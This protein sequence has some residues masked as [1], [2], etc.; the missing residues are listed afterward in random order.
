M[1]SRSAA[2]RKVIQPALTDIADCGS[3]TND[4]TALQS[5]I[6]T[7]QGL[8]AELA[9]ADMQALPDGEGLRSELTALWTDSVNADSSYMQWATSNTCDG[10]ADP[11]QAQ[12]DAYSQQATAEKV[13]F[14]AQWDPIAAQFGLHHRD[15]S[16]I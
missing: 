5:A 15:Q 10:S 8:I 1:L 2:A 4:I 12:G 7:R 6:D 3:P 13:T 9:T 16:Q 11:N 14:L